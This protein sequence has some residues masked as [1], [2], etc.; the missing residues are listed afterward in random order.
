MDSAV[1]LDFY[2]LVHDDAMNV[3]ISSD[4]RINAKIKKLVIQ[5]GYE[6]DI[7]PDKTERLLDLLPGDGGVVW[8]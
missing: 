2:R 1:T 5:T 8:N 3:G 7:L 4:R 6:I